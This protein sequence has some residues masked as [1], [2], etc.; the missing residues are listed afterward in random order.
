MTRRER[1]ERR[2]ARRREWAA[3][4]ADKADTTWDAVHNVPLPPAGEPIKI[5]HH[6][7]KRHRAALARMD[8]LATKA[9]EHAD[10]AKH[11]EERA[12]NI[13][14]HLQ[15]AVFSDDADAIDQLEA[16]IAK[17][18]AARDRIKRYNASCRAG[19]PDESVLSDAQQRDLASLKRI[20][21][22]IK[23][24]G[25]FPAYVLQNLS[26]NIKRD[27]DRIKKLRRTA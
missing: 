22:F 1:L 4:R 14:A 16:R 8:A 10:M 25:Q 11:H 27:K 5:G 24:D 20:S 23:P 15:R 17:R 12:D 9:I 2:A 6:S 7:E 26:A 18:E 19:T 13:E 21:A 3:K